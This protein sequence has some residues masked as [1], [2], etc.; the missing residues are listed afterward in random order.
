MRLAVPAVLAPG[1]TRLS[2]ALL[3]GRFATPTAT[4]TVNVL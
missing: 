3:D 1:T 2:W 4:T